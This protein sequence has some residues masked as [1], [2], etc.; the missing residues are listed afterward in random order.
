MIERL[1]NDKLLTEKE[2]EALKNPENV[3]REIKIGTQTISF[4]YDSNNT[5]S[6]STIYDKDTQETLKYLTITANGEVNIK[7][8]ELYYNSNTRAFTGKNFPLEKIVIPEK[9]KGI[10]VTSLGENFF[11][12]NGVQ[13]LKLP[14]TVTSIVGMNDE[15]I[16]RFGGTSHLHELYFY[17]K[18]EGY[19]GTLVNYI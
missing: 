13:I 17:D 9:I 1:H 19:I 16:N 2:V 7:D 10:T 14:N 12:G 4:N 3:N 18:N 15:R 6:D 11:I 5:E 8:A